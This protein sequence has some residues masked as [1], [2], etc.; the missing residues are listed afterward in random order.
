MTVKVTFGGPE[1]QLQV[2]DLLIPAGVETEVSD[3][4]ADQLAGHPNVSFAFPEKSPVKKPGDR[5]T[6]MPV[7]E[8][9]MKDQ[10][11]DDSGRTV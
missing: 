6:V 2:G 4:V 10:K 11:E 5:T 9:E 1:D 8:P 3:E 7:K